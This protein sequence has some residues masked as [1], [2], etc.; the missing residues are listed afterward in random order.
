MEDGNFHL[1]YKRL[2]YSWPFQWASKR[3]WRP[4]IQFSYGHFLKMYHYHHTSDGVLLCQSPQCS[5]FFFFDCCFLLTFEI[6]CWGAIHFVQAC[7]RNW[8]RETYL[9]PHMTSM[10][11]GCC[12]ACARGLLNSRFW[13]IRR[14]RFSFCCS[15]DYKAKQTIFWYVIASIVATPVFQSLQCQH[16]KEKFWHTQSYGN[17]ISTC[18]AFSILL[19]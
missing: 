16:F 5:T 14:C 3:I 1:G 11:L 9:L 6:N 19:T 12:K 4:H 10:P 17:M 7:K 2:I 18:T 15:S 8:F 13:L